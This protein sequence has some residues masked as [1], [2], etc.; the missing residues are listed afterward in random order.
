MF[1]LILTNIK[2]V[3]QWKAPANLKA[4]Q[5]FLGFCSY[6]KHFIANYLSI[7]HP[8][9]ELTR[10]YLLPQKGH[11]T[12]S[13]QTKQYL[14]KSEPFGDR[15]TP[16][17]ADAFQKV[18][19]CLTNAPVLTFADPTMSYILH[20]DASFDGLGAVLNQECPEGLWPVAF[21]SRKLSTPKRNYPVH[22]LEV[23][24]LK[25]AVIDKFHDYLY[26]AHFT[27]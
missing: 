10:G 8:L 14:C 5:S 17:C 9:T 21:A 2:A 25:W 12:K 18:R 23:L 4:R 19:N 15:W 1:P 24:A 6:Y 13:N 27:V 3:A 11:P 22:Q 16:A 26:G 20:V 7:V